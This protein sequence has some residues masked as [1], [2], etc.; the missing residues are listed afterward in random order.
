VVRP[1]PL[2]AAVA[3]ICTLL[4]T[5]AAAAPDR[6]ANAP[7]SDFVDR[8]RA[9]EVHRV[10]IDCV[11]HTDIANGSEQNGQRFFRPLEDVTR[12]QMATFIIQTLIAA[13]YGD[14]LPSGETTEEDP[15]EFSDI[16]G[17]VHRERINQLARIGVASGF[18]DGRYRPGIS[19][20]RQQMAS[21][22]LQAAEFALQRDFAPEGT[23]FADVPARN[24]HHDNID[25]GYEERLFSGTQAPRA[26][27]PDSGR[28]SPGRAVRRDQMASFLTNLLDRAET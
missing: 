6:C 7:Q 21:F 25:A 23:Y 8:D 18:S 20:S 24:V 9:A 22:L 1:L 11:D 13:G 28:F 10:S 4:A 14:E 19:V 26:G 17:T 2:A 16:S 12:G 15:D 27:V 5:P 3:V